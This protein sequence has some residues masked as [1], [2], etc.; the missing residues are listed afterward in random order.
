MIYSSNAR[1]HKETKSAL[2]QIKRSKIKIDIKKTPPSFLTN[3][4]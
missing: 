1:R 4:L 3:T 2:T